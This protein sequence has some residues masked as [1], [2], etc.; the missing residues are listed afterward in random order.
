MFLMRG[1][2]GL[3]GSVVR[4]TSVHSWAPASEKQIAPGGLTSVESVAD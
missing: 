2:L 1:V 4:P 3:A